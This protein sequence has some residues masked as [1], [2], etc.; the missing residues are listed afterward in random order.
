MYWDQSHCED[1]AIRTHLGGGLGLA[2]TSP[3]SPTLQDG[4]MAV[5]KER[6][7]RGAAGP[8]GDA[9]RRRSEAGESRRTSALCV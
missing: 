9:A 4:R 1:A 5:P 6:R 8:P 2:G 3:D 7:E